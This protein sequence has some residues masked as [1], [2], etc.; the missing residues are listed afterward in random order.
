MFFLIFILFFFGFEMQKQK[1]H[2]VFFVFLKVYGWRKSPNTKKNKFF[3]CIS[4]P[5]KNKENKKHLLRLNQK[6]SSKLC[7]FFWF[8][9]SKFWGYYHSL[10]ITSFQ[11]YQDNE[12]GLYYLC[13]C[14]ICMYVCREGH[15]TRGFEVD[16][17]GGVPYTY[18]IQ[19]CYVILCTVTLCN[20]M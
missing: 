12:Q 14:F 5:K 11:M 15:D 13:V 7:F 17:R 1:K 16:L 6:V 4:K 20:L 10:H 8:L 2:C 19:L 18:N 9:V 3:F